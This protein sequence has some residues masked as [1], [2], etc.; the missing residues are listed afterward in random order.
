MRYVKNFT[1]ETIGYLILCQ[2]LDETFLKTGNIPSLYNL[3]YFLFKK[4]LY[5][6]RSFDLKYYG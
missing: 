4:S 6:L 3:D 2:I 5:E 1:I